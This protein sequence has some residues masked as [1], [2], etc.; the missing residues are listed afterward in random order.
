MA[1]CPKCGAQN[2]DGMIYCGFCRAELAGAYQKPPGVQP[3][4]PQQFQYTQPMRTRRP[5][6]LIIIALLL[7]TILIVA[8]AAAFIMLPRGVQ[9]NGWDA[10]GYS[11]AVVG[12]VRFTVNLTNHGSEAVSKSVLCTVVFDN[13]DS[14]SKTESVTLGPGETK[15]IEVHVIVTDFNHMTEINSEDWASVTCTLI[16]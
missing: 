15:T 16:S 3:A 13:G 8:I 4:Q 12:D 6:V 11:L 1:T 14:Y 7:V 10:D 2:P 5:P 9:I